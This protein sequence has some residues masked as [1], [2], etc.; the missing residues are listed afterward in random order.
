MIHS[1]E[2][3]AMQSELDKMR[4]LLGVGLDVDVVGSD[5]FRQLQSQLGTYIDYL[6]EI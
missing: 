6:F 4:A 2:W 3:T 5:Q 1:S